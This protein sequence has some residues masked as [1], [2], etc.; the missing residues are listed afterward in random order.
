M[1]PD[2]LA[3]YAPLQPVSGCE[4]LLAHQASD[5]FALWLAWEEATGERH[6]VPFWA[7]VWPAAR[8]LARWLLD[9]PASV[10][11]RRV[12][13]F[14]CGGG[15]VAIAAAVAGAAC[16]IANDIDPVAL[17]VAQRNAAANG[18]SLDCTVANLLADFSFAPVDLVLVADLFYEKEQAVRTRHFLERLRAQGARVVIAD[19]GR[20]FAPRTGVATLAHVRVEVDRNLEGVSEREVTLLEMA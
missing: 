5:V 14:G 10:G 7:T 18:A 6:D 11:G 2:L 13:D 3:R 16:V 1:L 9:H 15:V 8:V 19:A 20:P 17:Q 4:P 12:L